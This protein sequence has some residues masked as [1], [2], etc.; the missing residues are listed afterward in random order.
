MHLIFDLDGTLLYTLHDLKNAVN[1]A[2]QRFRFPPRSLDE[3]QEAVGNGLKMLIVR[4]LPKDVDEHT[5]LMVLG[6]MKSYYSEHC[7]DETVPYDGIIEMLKEL[8]AAGHRISIVSNKADS[9][10]QVLATLYF[11]KLIDFSLGETTALPRKPAPDMVFAAMEKLGTNAVYI[12]DS[13]VD[14]LTAKNASIPC[15]SVAWGYRNAAILE[16]SGAERICST[17]DALLSLLIN[18]KPV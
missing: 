12:G 1:Y 4:S 8:K 3:I 11:G 7:H 15:I 17:P 9:M 5:I 2:L 16:K 13:E 6:E 18:T 10:V 14:I